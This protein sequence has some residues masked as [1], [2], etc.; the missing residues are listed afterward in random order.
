MNETKAKNVVI[1]KLL[2]LYINLERSLYIKRCINSYFVF[3]I[4]GQFP[5]NRE[6]PGEKVL[7]RLQSKL[8]FV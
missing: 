7:N 2:T 8:I 1:L 4:P 6:N 5:C 3:M